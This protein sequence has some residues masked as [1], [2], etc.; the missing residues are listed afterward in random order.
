MSHPRDHEHEHVE[1]HDERLGDSD[2]SL[3]DEVLDPFGEDDADEHDLP[4]RRRRRNPILMIGALIVAAAL[5]VGAAVFSFNAVR[6]LLPDMSFGGGE[7][8]PTDYEGEGSGEVVIEVP[9]GAGGGEIAEILASEDVVASASAFTGVLAADPR[10]GSIQP[11]TYR[12]A[13]QMSSESALE[14]LLD[15]AYREGV[16]VTIP[17]GLWASEIFT[18]LAEATDHEV[19]EY[20]EIDPAD[21][22]LPEAAEGELEGFLYPSTYDFGPDT[23][24]AQQLQTMIDRGQDVFAEL[25]IEEDDLRTVLIE[26]SIVQGEGMYGDDLPKIA[27]VLLNRYED[28]SETNGLLQMDSTIHY[29]H[30]ERGLAGTTS[31]QRDSDSPYNTYRFPGLPP[32]PI[33]NPGEEAIRAVLNPAQGDWMYF[34]TVN[35]DTGETKFADTYAEHQELEAEFLSW[36]EDNPDRC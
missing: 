13:Q 3:A 24:P 31:A 6:P 8:T 14:R 29:I 26:A 18:R 11:G 20:E 36:C 27:R 21:L 34:V 1:H 35:P 19:S 7:E 25:Q 4:R 2:G 32:G 16:R 10:S 9:P 28:N 22:E 33:N 23:E 17:E 12:M 5:V 15:D 30:Q